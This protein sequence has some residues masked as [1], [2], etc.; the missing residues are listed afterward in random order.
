MKTI[1]A[2]KRQV[3]AKL[4][5]LAW[6]AAAVTGFVVAGIT[7]MLWRGPVIDLTYD[8]AGGTP[9]GMAAAGW[10]VIVAPF[11]TGFVC[12]LLADRIGRPGRIALTAIAALLAV[13]ALWFMPGCGRHHCGPADGPLAF[14]TGTIFGA[15]AAIP[16]AVGVAA[17]AKHPSRRLAVILV[18]LWA[19]LMLALA[20][21]LAEM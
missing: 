20:L 9:A 19:L 5:E 18:S 11:L 15:L 3:R 10:L 7:G 21:V 8:V 1:R 2:N 12:W 13:V 6:T 17:T 4:L 14:Q 16:S